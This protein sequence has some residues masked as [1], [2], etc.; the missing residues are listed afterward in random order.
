MSY[1]SQKAKIDKTAV[2]GRCLVLGRSIVGEYSLID[3][4]VIIGYPVR[5][6]ILSIIKYS[7]G[8][9]ILHE[10][11]DK[12]SEGSEIG[13]NVLIRRGTVIYERVKLGDYV[14]TGHNVLV[15]ENT[16]IGRGTKIGTGT[17][18]DGNTTIGNGVNI[19]SGVYIPPMTVIKDNVFLG[20]FVIITNDRYPPSSR[21]LGV[22]IEEGAVIGAGAILLAGVKIGKQAV[23]GAGATVTRDVDENTVVV[24][25]PARFTSSRQV[26]ELKRRMYQEGRL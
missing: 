14:E 20:P 1:V 21:L 22:V 4:Y 24:G 18:I 23:V 25:T 15:R 2:L 19:Q 6:K 5:K 9:E 3:D 11:M 10:I 13:S 8:R 16:K 17:I 12:I 7:S 26:Y